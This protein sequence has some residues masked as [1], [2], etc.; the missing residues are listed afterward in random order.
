MTTHFQNLCCQTFWD[1]PSHIYKKVTRD[2]L[3]L[4]RSSSFFNRSKFVA[5]IILQ[6]YLSLKRLKW[7][8]VILKESDKRCLEIPDRTDGWRENE[9]LP[10]YNDGRNHLCSSSDFIWLT[11][12]SVGTCPVTSS[13]KRPSGSGSSPPGALGSSCWHSG[14]L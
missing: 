12:S 1:Q 7:W 14:M 13:Q 4:T 8:E 2:M 6:A 11:C 5:F 10:H 3:P 9:Q